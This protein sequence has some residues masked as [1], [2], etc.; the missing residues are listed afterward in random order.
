[1]RHEQ[2]PEG[3]GGRN[4]GGVRAFLAC[5]GNVMGVIIGLA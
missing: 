5:F 3:F 4:A 2:S 1:M